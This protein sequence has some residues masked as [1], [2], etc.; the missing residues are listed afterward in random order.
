[1]E[2]LLAHEFGVITNLIRLHAIEA[3]TRRALA[4]GERSLSYA[5][6]DQLMDR[7]A[8]ALQRE[9]LRPGDA[10]AICANTSVVYAAVFLGALRAGVAVAPLAPSSTPRSLARMLTDA[11]PRLLFGD[12]PNSR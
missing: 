6:L 4:D 12:G 11:Q 5:A 8:V 1:M 3:P 9:G 2:D 10:I 7:V